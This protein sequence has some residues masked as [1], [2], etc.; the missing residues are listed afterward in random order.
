MLDPYRQGFW[1]LGDR[2]RGSDRIQVH[3][4]LPLPASPDYAIRD[5]LRALQQILD[6]EA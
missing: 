1:V 4:N 3:R 6:I 5:H 2:F